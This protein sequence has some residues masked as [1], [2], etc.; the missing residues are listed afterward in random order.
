M[1]ETGL[2]MS[3]SSPN[4]TQNND[5]EIASESMTRP[6]N[7]HSTGVADSGRW[8]TKRI[9]MY[10]LFVRCRWPSALWNFPLCQA[11]NG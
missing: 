4:N 5:A 10:A 6:D 8:S 9:A 11:L 7:A 1:E 2:N 3:V